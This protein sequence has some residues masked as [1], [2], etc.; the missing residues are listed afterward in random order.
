[1]YASAQSLDFLAWTKKPFF[2]NRKPIV[3]HPEFP[4]G[5]Y[6]IVCYLETQKAGNALSRKGNPAIPWGPLA[7]RPRLATGL[8]FIYVV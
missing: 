2:S 6:L 5:N 3:S 8:A 1:M 7:F 4:D